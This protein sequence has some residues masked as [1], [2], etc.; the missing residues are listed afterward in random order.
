MSKESFHFKKNTTCKNCV[1][2]HGHN[3]SECRFGVKVESNIL[4]ASKPLEPCYKIVSD[5]AERKFYRAKIDRV[6][7]AGLEMVRA[8]S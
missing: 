3:G 1:F 6:F 8:K 7:K 5:S 2:L 4:K